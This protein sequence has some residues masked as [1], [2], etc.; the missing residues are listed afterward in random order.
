MA[1]RAASVLIVA[2]AVLPYYTLD[3]RMSSVMSEAHDVS[4]D[5]VHENEYCLHTIDVKNSADDELRSLQCHALCS[6]G[7]H[8]PECADYDPVI[9][10][11]AEDS[12]CATPEKLFALCGRLETCWGVT[13][14]T[15]LNHGYLNTYACSHEN[16]AVKPAEG[17]DVYIKSLSAP[18]AECQL[19]VGVVPMDISRQV[20]SLTCLLQV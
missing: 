18:H 8:T 11:P 13:H 15:G 4:F 10:G 17:R 12:L 5:E 6:G 3:N 1:L 16:S 14:N 9:D 2:N 20:L 7:A 19:G